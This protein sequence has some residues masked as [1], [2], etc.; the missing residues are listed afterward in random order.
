MKCTIRLLLLNDIIFFIVKNREE[1]VLQQKRSQG[2]CI[3]WK[4]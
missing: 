4:Y 1:A 2:E 3:I